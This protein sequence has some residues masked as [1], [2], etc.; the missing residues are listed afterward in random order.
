MKTL[1]ATIVVS[2]TLLVIQLSSLGSPLSDTVEVSGL[3]LNPDRVSVPGAIVSVVS[4]QNRQKPVFSDNQ[5][6]FTFR[7]PVGQ[8]AN[9]YVEIYWN[10]DLMFRNE[11]RELRIQGGASNFSAIWNQAFNLG[12]HVDLEPIVLGK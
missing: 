10:K 12:G 5:G 11:L 7:V 4:T 3:I 6:R 2:L 8:P 9:W 1:A